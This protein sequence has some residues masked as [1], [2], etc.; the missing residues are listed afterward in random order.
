MTSDANCRCRTV[1]CIEALLFTDPMTHSPLFS[2]CYRRC[3]SVFS[4]CLWCSSLRHGAI[5]APPPGRLSFR[6]FDCLRLQGSPRAWTEAARA[7]SSDSSSHK[8]AASFSRRFLGRRRVP[9]FPPSID[10]NREGFASVPAA[11]PFC[12]PKTFFAP[13]IPFTFHFSSSKFTHTT[14][15]AHLSLECLPHNSSSQ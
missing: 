9:L 11:A 4:S 2:V 12:C 6:P 15:S 5:T 1:Q 7:A 8:T 10:Q 13:H 3:C 14:F